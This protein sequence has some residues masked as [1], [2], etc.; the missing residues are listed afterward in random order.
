M[1]RNAARL[2]MFAAAVLAPLAT[3]CGGKEKPT[4]A[5]STISS[6]AVTPAAASSSQPESSSTA[7]ATL[8]PANVSYDDAEL[9]FRQ[10]NYTEST[11]LFTGYTAHNP[12]NA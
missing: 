2:S 10:G 12:E 1:S 5:T 9:A 7:V 4:T 3:G 8:A 11:E 6:G